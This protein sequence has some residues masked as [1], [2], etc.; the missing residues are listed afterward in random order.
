MLSLM[1]TFMPPHTHP[2]PPP[3]AVMLSP[4][5]ASVVS[6][7]YCDACQRSFASEQGVLQHLRDAWRH[8][9]SM[10]QGE[11]EQRVCVCVC[12]CPPCGRSSLLGS[13]E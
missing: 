6:S 11:V 3:A 5:T 13:C 9:G 4:W 7:L 12:V 1:L 8:Q 10:E 2:A